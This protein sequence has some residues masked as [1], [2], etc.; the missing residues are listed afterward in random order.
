MAL[1]WV[2][3]GYTGNRQLLRE[4]HAPG[5]KAQSEAEARRRNVRGLVHFSLWRVPGKRINLWWA[6]VSQHQRVVLGGQGEPRPTGT[7][8]PKAFQ[9]Q[10]SLQ[11]IVV[12]RHAKDARF[13]IKLKEVHKF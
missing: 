1:K 4:V 6:D 3:A 10:D 2:E 8:F 11:L 9:A 7:Y 5:L 13:T 12:D